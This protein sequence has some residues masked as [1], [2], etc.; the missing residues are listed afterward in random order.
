M[1]NSSHS[2]S[3]NEASIEPSLTELN[4]FEEFLTRFAASPR[5]LSPPSSSTASEISSSLRASPV[6]TQPFKEKIKESSMTKT[7]LKRGKS[8][9]GLVSSS[10]RS[11]SSKSK[12]LASKGFVEEDVDEDFYGA[13]D[14]SDF[15]ENE[16]YDVVSDELSSRKKKTLVPK[17]GLRKTRSVDETFTSPTLYSSVTSDFHRACQFG[18]IGSLES[19]W[20][21]GEI[22]DVT[23]TDSMQNTGLHEAVVNGHWEV[24]R[25]LLKHGADVLAKNLSGKTPLDLARIPSINGFLHEFLKRSQLRTG[26]INFVW[27]DDLSGLSKRLKE[28]LSLDE[29]MGFVNQSDELGFTALHTAAIFDR[30]DLAKILL[31]HGAD[32][33]ASSQSGITPLHDACRFSSPE[34]VKLLLKSGADPTK[35]NSAGYRSFS[36]ANRPIRRLFRRTLKEIGFVQDEVE[37]AAEAEV[38]IHFEDISDGSEDESIGEQRT[39]EEFEDASGLFIKTGI[40]RE[41]RKLQQMLAIMN[42]MS[43]V[44]GSSSSSHANAL[45]KKPKR[46]LTEA[47]VKKSEKLLDPDFRDKSYGTT[48]LH[49]H[50]GKGN[51]REVKQLLSGKPKLVHVKDNAGYTALHEAALNGHLGVV[52]ALLDAGADIDVTALNGDTPL[53][54]AAENGHVEVVSYLLQAGANRIQKNSDGKIPFD[55]AN[56]PRIKSML[57]MT[58][59]EASGRVSR[60]STT[61][62]KKSPPSQAVGKKLPVNKKETSTKVIKEPS[63]DVNKM[64]PLLL[65]RVGEP[66]GWYFLSPQIESLYCAAAKKSSPASL[67]NRHKKLYE[68]ALLSPIQRQHLILSPLLKRLEDL[69]SLLSDD[70]VEAVMLE[71][72][73]VYQALGSMGIS[74]GHLN[75]IYLDLQRI[76]RSSLVSSAAATPASVPSQ[77]V[78]ESQ[79]PPKL[80]MKMARKGSNAGLQESPTIAPSIPLPSD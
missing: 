6:S 28:E 78:D 51:L 10:K 12:A 48:L 11:R 44:K 9:D 40:S 39:D 80:K 64:G 52:K 42:R 75:V 13:Q 63:P 77:A 35:R 56:N 25:F 3:H 62:I 38:I 69:K 76:M 20:K 65:V 73:G 37:T 57:E 21:K 36:M 68:G 4:G 79:L 7:S 24:I 74:F 18:H 45:I 26:A 60:S 1:I 14:D 17:N 47:I 54:D 59:G 58:G 43:P 72:D 61:T 67:R 70:S 19:M 41:E 33:N 5:A 30:S 22:N 71:K 34:C 55:V 8:E 49:K 53:H 46:P 23:I 66:S 16:D 15:G 2:R 50:S 29:I 31:K 32:I 27:N